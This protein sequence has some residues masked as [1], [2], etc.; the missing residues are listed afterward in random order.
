MTNYPTS[1]DIYL[2]IDG[3]KVAVVQNYSAVTSKKSR[4]VEAFGEDEPVATI[5]GHSTHTL[6]LSRLYATDS[7]IS[8]GISFHDLDGFSLVIVKPDRK[9][10]YTGCHWS[11]ISERGELGEMVLESVKLVAAGR[12]ESSL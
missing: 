1:A 3:K 8:D 12:I 10:I 7:A 6:E 4:T 2:E 11:D 5:A 9:V